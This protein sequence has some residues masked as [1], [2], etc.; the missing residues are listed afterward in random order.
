M[1]ETDP[2]ILHLSRHLRQTPGKQSKTCFVK[3]KFL[4]SSEASHC[5]YYPNT[6]SENMILY[7][8]LPKT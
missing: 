6:Q 2:N 8:Y 3:R 5:F 4:P 1:G 7:V